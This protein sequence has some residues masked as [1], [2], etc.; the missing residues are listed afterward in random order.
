VWVGENIVVH[1]AHRTSSGGST[2][3][4]EHHSLFAKT[5]SVAL[6]PRHLTGDNMTEDGSLRVLLDFLLAEFVALGIDY[7]INSDL[8]VVSIGLFTAKE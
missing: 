1:D 5:L 4:E 7:V 3:P 6:R 2:T 8:D